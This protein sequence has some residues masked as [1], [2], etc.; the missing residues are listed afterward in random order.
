MKVKLGGIPYVYPI[1]IVIAG[2]NVHGTPNYT[3]L[4]D[5]GIMGIT[6]PLVYVSSHCEHYLNQGILENGTYSINFPST[7]LLAGGLGS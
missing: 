5:C 6:P 7:D 1:P 3:T 4:G 2:A